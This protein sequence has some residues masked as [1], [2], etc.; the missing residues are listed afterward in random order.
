[1]SLCLGSKEE[2]SSTEDPQ[3]MPSTTKAGTHAQH[4]PPMRIPRWA[5]KKIIR[6]KSANQFSVRILVLLFHKANLGTM[7]MHRSIRSRYNR[8]RATGILK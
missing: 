3:S 8:F 1:M 4:S 6:I 5:N 2:G 7:G